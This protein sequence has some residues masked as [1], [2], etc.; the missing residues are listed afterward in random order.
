MQLLTSSWGGHVAGVNQCKLPRVMNSVIH[1]STASNAKVC[2]CTQTHQ[3]LAQPP[4]LMYASVHKQFRSKFCLRCWCKFLHAKT[5]QYIFGKHTVVRSCKALT[6][7]PM[8]GSVSQ[9]KYNGSYTTPWT[10]RY[11]TW[12]L[13]NLTPKGVVFPFLFFFSYTTGNVHLQFI[14]SQ[15]VSPVQAWQKQGAKLQRDTRMRTH[16]VKTRWIFA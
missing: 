14:N 15:S 2:L 10:A 1:L 8:S 16:G 3:Y 12:L 5:H 11:N 6:L 13:I 9:G 4:M 7:P